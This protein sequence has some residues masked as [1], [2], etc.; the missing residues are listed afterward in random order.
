MSTM[1]TEQHRPLAGLV[2]QRNDEGW[3][4]REMEKRANRA[5]HSISHS[6]LADYASDAVRKVPNREQIEALAAALDLGYETVRAAVFAQYY[7]YVPRELSSRKTSRVAAAVPSD[8]SP[9]EEGELVRMVE[10]WLS[11]RRHD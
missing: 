11:A 7:G 9:E 1:T 5:G 10:A 3:S 4:Y 6:Q 8:L 2:R